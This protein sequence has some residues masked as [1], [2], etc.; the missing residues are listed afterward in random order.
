[1]HQGEAAFQTDPWQTGS[2]GYSMQ[3]PTVLHFN[4]SQKII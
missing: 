3:D 4:I 1:M 2:V